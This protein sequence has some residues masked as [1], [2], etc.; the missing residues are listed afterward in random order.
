MNKRWLGRVCGLRGTCI[1]LLLSL[2]LVASSS[3]RLPLV[4]REVEKDN[5]TVVSVLGLKLSYS[6]QI[7]R[8][9]DCHPECIDV[10]LEP[11]AE[12]GKLLVEKAVADTLPKELSTSPSLARVLEY[13]ESNWRIVLYV[14]R[15][16]L[17]REAS[18]NSSYQFTFDFPLD[19][20]PAFTLYVAWQAPDST[21]YA[22]Y[23]LVLGSTEK[24]IAPRD[25]FYEGK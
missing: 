2:T 7:R 15:D 9:S 12:R 3:D 13:R 18:S 5:T 6:F 23:D 24:V 21:Q 17:I 4:E 16:T 20:K 10:R 19:Y 1:A 14:P 25:I 11:Q 22:M 8:G